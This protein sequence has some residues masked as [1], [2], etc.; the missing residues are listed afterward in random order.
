MLQ[1][2]TYEILSTAIYVQFD[3]G[4]YSFICHEKL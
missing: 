2:N 3:I 1:E 4:D